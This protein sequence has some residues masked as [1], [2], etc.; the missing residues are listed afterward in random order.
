MSDP[1]TGTP[2]TPPAPQPAPA[3]Q[4]PAPAPAPTT[5]Q[6]APV[7]TPPAPAPTT[8]QPPAQQTPNGKTFS[9]DDVDRIVNDRMD[10]FE[11]SF[12]EKFAGQL[13]TA[14]G[15]KPAEGDGKPTAEQMLAQAQQVVEQATTRANFA[16]ARSFAQAAQIKPERLD[17]LLGMVDLK[18]VLS[19]VDADNPSA[20]DA[21][22]KAAV[23]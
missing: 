15:G 12:G 20:V 13:L 22:I 5:A 21:A 7:P 18:A 9:Q 23:D 16:T 10:R 11:K 2:P 8:G 3:T 14:L 6:P 1:T 4:P 17:A 19:N